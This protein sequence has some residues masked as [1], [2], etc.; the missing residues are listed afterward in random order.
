MGDLNEPTEIE[1]SSGKTASFKEIVMLHVKQ[2]LQFGSREFRGG[3]Y[4]VFVSQNGTEKDI[5]VSDTRE[6][7][8]NAVIGL[9]FMLEPKFTPEA[10][11]AYEKYKTSLAA[12]KQDFITKSSVDEEVILG[13]GYYTDPKD[14]LLLETYKQKKLEKVQELFLA[15]S[16]LLAKLNYLEIGGG[17]F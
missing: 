3:Y 13:E 1:M 16:Q 15:L 5:Y 7:F 2:I 17:T 4:T 8:G 6:E 14:K 10:K 12:L 11:E 9:A